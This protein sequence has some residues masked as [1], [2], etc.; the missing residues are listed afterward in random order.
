[1]SK[2]NPCYKCEDRH[3]SCHST[4]SDYLA[5]RENLNKEA[6]AKR[7]YNEDLAYFMNNKKKR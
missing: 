1:M 3:I 4:C 5:F 6:E 7:K 2:N